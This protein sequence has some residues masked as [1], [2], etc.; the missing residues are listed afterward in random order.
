MDLQVVEKAGFCFGVKRVIDMAEAVPA[1]NSPV[2]LPGAVTHIFQVIPGLDAK[3]R[4]HHAPA[5][6]CPMSAQRAKASS[7]LPSGRDSNN[8]R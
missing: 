4:S 5:H 1:G 3:V 6:T 7:T 8:R 2:S